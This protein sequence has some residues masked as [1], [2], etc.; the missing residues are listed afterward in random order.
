MTRVLVLMSTWNGA[1][2]IDAQLAS[3]LAQ[4]FD[5]RID[6]L[7]RDDGSTDGTLD[8][9]GRHDAS[10]IRVVR[11]TNLGAKASF[12]ELLELART[13]K[14]DYYALAD[15]DDVWLPGKVARAVERLSGDRPA[16]YCTSLHLVDGDLR[17]LARYRHPG[18]RTFA[19][20]LLA[21]FVTGCTCVMNR[22][23]LDR[24]RPPLD[25][26][27]IIMHDWWL[28]SAAAA[29]GSVVYD[30]Q[31]F[32]EY[33]QHGSNQVGI[34]RGLKGLWRRI[35]LFFSRSTSSRPSRV[36]QARMLR[37]SYGDALPQPARDTL[38]AFIASS[39]TIRGR[40]QFVWRHRRD[41][42]KVTALR[43]ALRP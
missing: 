1:R 40:L 3:I 34:A 38:D 12:V 16:L 6:I 27:Q 19:S 4:A 2:Y 23:M 33:R 32:T 37:L 30:E 18:A 22:A 29:C 35:G 8:I 36:A 11:G 7:I 13:S 9:I 28:A 39:S 15:Q 17:S 21:N 5:G 42:S 26:G 20:S 41:L 10:R 14:A 43:F 25:R 31:S 24:V